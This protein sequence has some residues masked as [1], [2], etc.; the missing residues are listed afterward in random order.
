[1]KPKIVVVLYSP[2]DD[3]DDEKITST[4]TRDIMPIRAPIS[5][6]HCSE[7]K[8][9]FSYLHHPAPINNLSFGNC[10]NPPSD[11]QNMGI[12]GNI[13]LKSD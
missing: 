8:H 2:C 3:D 9:K 5:D 1:M 7:P 11:A 13:C 12:K 6:F 4:T 10:T